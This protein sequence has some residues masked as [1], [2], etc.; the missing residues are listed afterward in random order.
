MKDDHSKKGHALM[1]KII[2]KARTMDA[3]SLNSANLNE[4]E[5]EKFDFNRTNQKS[6]A[7]TQM[8]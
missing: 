5:L 7:S 6:K 1:D 4:R 8:Q 2:H 3:S